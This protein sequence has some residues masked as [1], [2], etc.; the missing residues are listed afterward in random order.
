MLRTSQCGAPG[1]PRREFLAVDDLAD[2]CVFVM[3]YY[4]DGEIINIGTGRDV[5]IKEFA[6][7]VAD[8]VGYEG[9]IV[10]DRTRPDGMPQKLLDVS[11]LTRLGWRARTS[12]KDG[13]AQA[14]RD[15]VES[16]VVRQN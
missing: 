4:S 10:F 8:V 12:L 9:R 7:Y 14:Y 15:F 6:T 2:A 11:K 3:K 16:G 1:A 13:L 5:T